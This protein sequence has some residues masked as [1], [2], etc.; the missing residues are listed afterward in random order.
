MENTEE[1]IAALEKQIALQEKVILGLLDIFEFAMTSDAE[2]E[3]SKYDNTK[4]M[5]FSKSSRNEM[6]RLA[7]ML[8]VQKYGDLAVG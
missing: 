3:S 4:D 7:E 5:T 1:R 6:H 2:S 8:G